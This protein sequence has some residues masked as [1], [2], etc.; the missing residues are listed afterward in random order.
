MIKLLAIIILFS[1]LSSYGQELKKKRKGNE[2]FY[3]LKSDESVRQGEYLKS[4]TAGIIEKGQYDIN[5]KVGIWEFYGLEGT[6]EQKYDYSNKKLALND[7]FTSVST[8]YAIVTNGNIT[9]IS[10]DEKP[11]LIGGPS[12]YFRHVM[13]NMH[14]PP[15]ARTKGTQGK[16][17]ITAVVNSDGQLTDIKVL[18]GLGEGCDEEALRVINS[19]KSEWIPGMHNGEKVDVLVVLSIIYRLG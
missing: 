2:T 12:S 11:I 1:F 10:P 4:G 8:R 16:V 6:L 14:Y 13:E 17:F 3:V 18:Q 7:N 15:K 5:K 19:F 9:E